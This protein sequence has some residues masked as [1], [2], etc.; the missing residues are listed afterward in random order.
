ML[1]IKYQ[2]KFK[3]DYK[4]IAKRG[5]DIYLLQQVVTL[6]RNGESLPVCLSIQK[7]PTL[8]TEKGSTPSAEGY[9]L[10]ALSEN[11]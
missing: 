4:N 8:V 6:L 9:P 5:Y 3:K 7:G 1:E 10:F 11:R 2:S